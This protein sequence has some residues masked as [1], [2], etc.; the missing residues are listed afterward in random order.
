MPAAADLPDHIETL[1]RLVIESQAA[2]EAAEAQLLSRQLEIQTLKLQIA[3]LKRMQ[4]GRSSEQLNEKIAQ[5]E[6]ALEDLEAAEAATPAAV[7]AHK[8]AREKSV[9]RPLSAH[10]PR[11]N[12]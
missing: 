10:L 3:Q 1:K 5:L 2:L 6:F 4:F 12:I 8:T 7:P 11:E 9:R